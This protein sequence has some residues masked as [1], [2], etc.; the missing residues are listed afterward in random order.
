MGM[1]KE[2]R[3]FAVKGN[4]VDMAVGLVIGAAFGKIVTSLVNDI[5]MPPI[6]LLLG[7]ADFSKLAIQLNDKTA[8]H[9]GMFI[10]AVL[11]FLI[12]AF[13]IFLVVKQINRLKK[14]PAPVE[15]TTKN[16][17]KCC[18]DIP[19]KAVRCPHCTSELARQ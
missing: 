10:N 2:F 8:V 17:P 9:Y 15:P 1:L 18:S 19:V 13:A 3:E 6:G 4:A 11:D 5:M 16:C 7:K 12:V 14:A